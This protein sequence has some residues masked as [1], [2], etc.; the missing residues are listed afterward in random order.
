MSLQDRIA[1]QPRSFSVRP[2]GSMPCSQPAHAR[3]SPRA[4]AG[5]RGVA[6]AHATP[7]RATA[8][9]T[10]PQPLRQQTSIPP[11]RHT[12]S[13]SPRLV[14]SCRTSRR[15]T[16]RRRRQRSACQR[17]RRPRAKAHPG[18]RP[19]HPRCHRRARPSPRA[20]ATPRPLSVPRPAGE[21]VTCGARSQ[22]ECTAEGVR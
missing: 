22:P 14:P 4:P 9:V 7:L 2:S 10:R 5:R 21:I 11:P 20:R 8:P 3:L 15:R 16:A 1:T 17:R 18:P 19:P 6:H 13:G 12:C